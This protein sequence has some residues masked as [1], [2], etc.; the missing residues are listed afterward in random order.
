MTT[1]FI[2]AGTIPYRIE[3]RSI[4]V[5]LITT[6]SGRNLTIPKGLIDPGYTATETAVNEAWEEAGIKG[7][8]LTPAIGTYEFNKWGGRCHVDVYVLAVTQESDPWPEKGMRKRIWTDFRQAAC[9][10]KHGDLGALIIKL[11]EFLRIP[12]LDD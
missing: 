12:D 7:R 5:L 9:R 10:V 11:P 1:R 2:Q 8:L 6:S 4:Q 3:D